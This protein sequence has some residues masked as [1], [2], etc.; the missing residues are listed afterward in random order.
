MIS[1]PRRYSTFNIA[2][3]QRALVRGAVKKVSEVSGRT[4][5][6]AQFTR[7]AFTAHLRSI[8]ND[9]NDGRPIAPVY[10]DDDDDDD[11]DEG[12]ELSTRPS[13]SVSDDEHHPRTG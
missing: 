8:W 11:T 13:D 10:D 12:D 5:T 1:R 6:F 4:Y 7:D 3:D 2:K 9:Y